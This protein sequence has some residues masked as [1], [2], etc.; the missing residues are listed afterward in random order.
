MGRQ[1]WI[2][3]LIVLSVILVDALTKAIALKTLSGRP[4][5]ELLPRIS[6]HLTLNRGLPM[7]IGANNQSLVLG[8]G[9]ILYAA[10][11]VVSSLIAWRKPHSGLAVV[12]AGL[13][14]GG[15]IA[16]SLDRF[17]RSGVV[18]FIAF[19]V[20]G[21]SYVVVNCADLFVW[22]ASTLFSIAVARHFAE[23]RA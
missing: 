4:P 7:G 22:L 23:M 17:F 16:N 9:L 13:V 8:V 10:M 12:T 14:A 21:N 2:F 3:V 6:F 5:I 20:K 18:D 11:V 1:R 19:N 15:A